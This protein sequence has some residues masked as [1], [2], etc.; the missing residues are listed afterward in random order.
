MDYRNITPDELEDVLELQDFV[1][2]NLDD[3]EVLETIGRDEFNEMIEQ[4]FIIGIF[5]EDELKA[6]RAMYI[7]PLDDP[8]HLAEDGGVKDRTQVI[9]SEITFIH[10]EERG[11]GLQTRLGHELLN[12]VREDGRFK[13]VFTTVMP[14]NPPSLKDKL[15]L[16]FK[17]I[18]TRH[19]YGGKLRHV[20]QLNLEDPLEVEGEP[21]K[22]NYKDTNWMLENGSKY[23]GTNFDGTAIE[24]YLKNNN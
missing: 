10:P 22:I 24:Y 5:K 15:R 19:M 2:D 9:Y 7:P 12:K 3:K 1:Y 16:G 20:L 23:I 14:T 18:N 6:V 17:I 8:E 13:Y 4:G 11:Q 21:E